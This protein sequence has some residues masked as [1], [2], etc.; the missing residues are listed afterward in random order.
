[1]FATNHFYHQHVRKA[2]I[3]FGTIFNGIT[4]RRTNADGTVA[5]S[6]KVPLHYAPKQKIIARV[7]EVNNLE[8]DRAKYSYTLPRMAFEITELQYDPARH[9]NTM[10][11]I[12]STNTETDVTRSVFVAAPYTIGLRLSIFAKNQ[13]DGL[14]ILEQILP[15]FTPDFNVT[16][17]ELPEA[18]VKRDLNIVLNSVRY[19]DMYEGN[20]NERTTI[21]WDLSFSLK[22]N[23][24]GS[25][26]NAELIKKVI[27]NIYAENTDGTGVGTKYTGL[28]TDGRSAGGIWSNIWA[29]S[30]FSDTLFGSGEYV[31]TESNDP[32]D[33]QFV[34]E[35][36]QVFLGDE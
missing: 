1:M 20:F 8:T 2:I 18:N 3:S 29:P 10:Q 19:D 6:L 34:E 12:R 35:F 15:F 28:A 25:V 26:S 17:N 24:Y 33:Y 36:E 4:I 21:L 31:M 23:F 7:L 22:M 27:A 9:M 16:I 5:Q 11:T 14:Q 13:D 30:L 32:T